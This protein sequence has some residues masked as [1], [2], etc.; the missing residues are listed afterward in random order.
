MKAPE[1]TVYAH[2]KKVET[3]RIKTL[4]IQINEDTYP[5]AIACLPGGFATIPFKNVNGA[6]LVINRPEPCFIDDGHRAIVSLENGWLPQG[7]F[8]AE[9]NIVNK[10][11][12]VPAKWD[13][14]EVERAEDPELSERLAKAERATHLINYDEFGQDQD[15]VRP[16]PRKIRKHYPGLIEK[17]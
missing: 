13:W 7:L 4:A 6:Y 15:V 3:M 12:G 1:D 2:N 17:D 14:V 16:R 9:Y 8:E 10:K 11:T 5:I